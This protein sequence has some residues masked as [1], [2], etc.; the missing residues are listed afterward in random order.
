MAKY[1]VLILLLLLATGCNKD[2]HEQVARD[3]LNV[4]HQFV[5]TCDSIVDAEA[6]KESKEKLGRLLDQLK[7]LKTRS[8]QLGVADEKTRTTIESRYD[9]EF[10]SLSKH[11]TDTVVK[12]ESKTEVVEQLES[13]LKTLANLVN[14]RPLRLR[15]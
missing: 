12:L 10:A 14:A 8:K 1:S 11:F 2:T 7:A 3:Y 6:A 5:K 13:E 9:E 4:M 15:R